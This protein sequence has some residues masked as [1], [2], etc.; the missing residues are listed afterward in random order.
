MTTEAN[1]N[2]SIKI[3]EVR[4]FFN[5]VYKEKSALEERHMFRFIIESNDFNNRSRDA[6]FIA[7]ELAEVLQY[8]SLKSILSRIDQKHKLIL[9]K[10]DILYSSNLEPFK[11]IYTSIEEVCSLIASNRGILLIDSAAA[12]Q[13]IYRSYKEETRPY[14]QWL[15]ETVVPSLFTDYEYTDKDT[16]KHAI[17]GM[18]NNLLYSHNTNPSIGEDKVLYKATLNVNDYEYARVNGFFSIGEDPIIR[19]RILNIAFLECFSLSIYNT[20]PAMNILQDPFSIAYR[21]GGEQAVSY[22]H[23]K[24][25][26]I[27]MDLRYGVLLEQLEQIAWYRYNNK[28]KSHYSVPDGKSFQEYIKSQNDIEKKEMER[29]YND[30]KHIYGINIDNLVDKDRED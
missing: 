14:K 21:I 27:V 28:I 29:L 8:S 26:S 17:D 9:K 5:V 22:L 20:D 15:E 19:G 6:W 2:N 7:N 23:S 18:F 4:K 1:K 11:L 10:S 13:I 3:L 16:A 12:N 24:I 30:G 25:V